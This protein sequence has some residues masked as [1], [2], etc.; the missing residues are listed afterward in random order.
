[1][2]HK[3]LINLGT[4]PKKVFD[5]IYSVYRMKKMRINTGKEYDDAKKKKK[6]FICKIA[7]EE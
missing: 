7:Y 1:M 4:A 3:F 6:S 2:T 5:V